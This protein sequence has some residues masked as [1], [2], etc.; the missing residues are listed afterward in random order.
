MPASEAGNKR[1]L[2]ATPDRL[3]RREPIRHSLP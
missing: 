3:D 2:R 1:C